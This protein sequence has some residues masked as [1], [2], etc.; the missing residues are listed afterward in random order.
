MVERD[1]DLARL[2]ERAA[3]ADALV[4]DV[5]ANGLF[6]YRPRL[7]TVQLAF[8]E[9]DA[10][11]VGIV[12]ALRVRVAPLAPLLGAAGP[13]KVLHD[14]TFDARM[15]AEAG[16]PLGAA[17]DTSV[18]ARMLGCAA[19]GLAA[20]LASE[21]GVTIDKQLQQHDWGRR[22]LGSVELRYLTSDVLHLLALDAR[23]A[24]RSRA[25]DIEDEIAEECA[26]KLATALG[27]PRDPRPAYARIKGAQALDPEGRA[28]L[29]RLV[30]AR[31]AAAEEAD[32]PAFKIVASEVLL[33]LAQRKPAR[34]EDVRAVRGAAA[35]RAAPLA[36][37][38]LRAVEQGRSDGDVPEEERALFQPARPTRKELAARRAVESRIA[39]WR[40]AEAKARSVDEQV[41]LPG[42]CA[43][44]LLEIALAGGHAGDAAVA[45]AIARIPGLGARR[46]A[47]YGGALAALAAAPLPSEPPAAAT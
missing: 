18:A 3:R 47:R 22:P 19:T 12:D 2:V 39:A 37:A 33:E 29:R 7:C 9:G 4:V 38:W 17:R 30:A 13:P 28:I 44:E 36:A 21:L 11:A 35:G 42:H 26:Y 46:L 14:L 16:A 31:E 24:E 20:L 34:I 25:L 32:V 5:E 27:P 23:L 45:A 40:R 10:I 41:V 43:Q 6:V 8:R 1:A 15:L